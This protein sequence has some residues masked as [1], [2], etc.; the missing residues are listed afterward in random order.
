MKNDDYT[1]VRDDGPQDGWIPITKQL[2]VSRTKYIKVLVAHIK[3]GYVDSASF[4]TVDKTFDACCTHWK[5]FP[6]GPKE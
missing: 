6:K 4:N 3:N 2:P 1:L 5:Q